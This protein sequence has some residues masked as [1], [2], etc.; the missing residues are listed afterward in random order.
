[1]FDSQLYR[2]RD[3]LEAWRKRDPSQRLRAWLGETAMLHADD[4]ERSEAE[5]AA[6]LDAAVAFAEAGT[7]EKV[8]DLER[9]AIMDRVP[10]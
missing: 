10:Q 9:F 2:K 4:F 1:M 7:W 3:E 8:E 5:V 6:E